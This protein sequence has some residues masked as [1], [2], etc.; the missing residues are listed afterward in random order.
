MA[1]TTGS[2]NSTNARLDSLDLKIDRMG[3]KM[4]SRINSLDMKVEKRIDDLDTKINGRLDSLVERMDVIILLLLYPK[5]DLSA[6]ESRLQLGP[7]GQWASCQQRSE[8]CVY[9]F[10]KRKDKK[11]VYKG[12]KLYE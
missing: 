10:N 1:R 5:A 11:K 3:S 6:L 7:K 2:N 4:D 12:P 9:T 8:E